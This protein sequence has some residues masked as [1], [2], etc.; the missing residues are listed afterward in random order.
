MYT[1][2]QPNT[3]KTIQV[4]MGKSFDRHFFKK[5]I[6]MAKSAKDAQFH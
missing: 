2:L 6:Q 5:D 4:K 3:K 1:I